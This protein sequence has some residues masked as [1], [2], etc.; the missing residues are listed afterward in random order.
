M[1]RL[2]SAC[3][4]DKVENTPTTTD[5]SSYLVVER[6]FVTG[7]GRFSFSRTAS[8]QEKVTL[9]FPRQISS[10]N[11][12]IVANNTVDFFAS[13]AQLS[14]SPLEISSSE[15]GTVIPAGWQLVLETAI[16]FP[17]KINNQAPTWTGF[18]KA[19]GANRASSY[20]KTVDIVETGVSSCSN[21]DP[22][23]PC[24]QK[25]YFSVEDCK[26]IDYDK[27]IF[28]FMVQCRAKGTGV[29][30]QD[31]GTN[32]PNA[33]T[34][35]G[36]KVT[37]TVSLKT[38]TA[39]PFDATYTITPDSL[40]FY[41]GNADNAASATLY[42]TSETVYTRTTFALPPAEISSISV[43]AVCAFPSPF[44]FTPGQLCSGYDSRYSL[45]GEDYSSGATQIP[46]NSDTDK[47]LKKVSIGRAEK[48]VNK[49]YP[50]D[51]SYTHRTLTVQVDLKI[52]YSGSFRA[53]TKKREVD[54]ESQYAHSSIGSIAIGDIQENAQVESSSATSIIASFALVVL[55]SVLLC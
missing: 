36:W 39:C 2:N 5:I 49:A 30:G 32:C 20:L 1:N 10:K 14:Y 38:T 3:G 47:A 19:N 48:L 52:T 18:L 22:T 51:T 33:N 43:I 15:A 37:A 6:K 46:S 16:A 11:T 31:T 17:Y 23:L 35:A 42:G 45:A 28:Q 21:S 25:H 54:G 55:L 27:G 40:A 4:F 8:T 24:L 26:A 12:V 13:V 50:T 9:K 7:N 34:P 29:T 53:G 44:V 41:Q